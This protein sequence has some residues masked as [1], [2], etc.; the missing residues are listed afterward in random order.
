MA[1]SWQWLK[2]K[3]NGSI[4]E[5]EE[6]EEEEVDDDDDEGNVEVGNVEVGKV[7]FCS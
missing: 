5:V 2:G 6:E 1:L 4:E 3:F 7:E